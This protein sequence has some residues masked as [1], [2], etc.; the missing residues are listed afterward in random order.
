MNR[1]YYYK[2]VSP[3]EEDVTRN[4]KLTIDELDSNFFSLKNVDIKD[5]KL[6]E[7]KTQ[8]IL[9]RNDGDEITVEMPFIPNDVE[10]HLIHDLNVEYNKDEGVI[11]ISYNGDTIVIDGLLTEG[12][13]LTSVITDNSLRGDGTKDN[14]LRLSELEKTGMYAPVIR[15]IDIAGGGRL[16]DDP[17]INDRYLTREKVSR[18][19]YLYNFDAVKAIS[20]MLEADIS[21]WRIPT[22]ADWD[23]LLNSLE[24]CEYQ[25]H[26]SN[27]CH[28]VLGMY[29]GKILKSKDYWKEATLQ[30][31]I[32]ENGLEHLPV[33]PGGIDTYGFS[34][35][36]T[37]YGNEDGE[38]SRFTE[39]AGLWSSTH[40]N[41][42][43][44]QDIFVKMFKYNESGVRQE[45]DCC[46][47]FHGVR[48][49]KNFDGKNY[50][51]SETI[52]GSP[53]GTYLFN[54]T[55]QI[56]TT[57]NL[58]YTLSGGTIAPNGGVDI[59]WDYV[60]FL[61]SFN[62]NSWDKKEL[63]AGDTVLAQHGEDYDNEEY[64][65]FVDEDGNQYIKSV[66][67]VVYERV[68]E[69]VSP[70]IEN[71][72]EERIA[73]DEALNTRVDQ[74]IA[75]RTSADEAL[76]NRITAEE[77]ARIAADEALNARVDQEVTERTEADNIIRAQLI[78]NP[79]NSVNP[80]T[81]EQYIIN[82]NPE[83]GA[84]LTLYSKGG[85]NDIRIY[86]DGNY[87]EL[88]NA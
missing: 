47:V 26:D 42:D 51:G 54:E 23:T 40:L 52:L 34:V 77:T 56:W 41:D 60:Y 7:D 32:D 19:G 4:C 72:R 17:S 21:E 67:D 53:Y 13:A 59:D 57:V 80:E 71:E 73:A 63:K 85:T 64:R 8:L 29:A 81:P 24:P 58:Y 22:K 12:S 35:L 16:P 86:F 1:I 75:E 87:G 74:E 55:S 61:N 88:P 62:G 33:Q 20:G 11:T 44:H 9:V 68:M 27:D 3:Y 50:H 36:P 14:P 76:S 84:N 39:C 78:D 5:A 30:P 2:L 79:E 15:V 83:E 37:G 10:P 66:D 28:K 38:A 43:E 25:N 82:A 65:V 69:H 49:V 31:Y 18:F 70:I 46:D 45:A 6:S 48:L